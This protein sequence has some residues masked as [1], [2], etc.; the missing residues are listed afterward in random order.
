MQ[1]VTIAAALLCADALAAESYSVDPRH[2]YPVFEVSHLGFS[3]QRGRFNKTAGKIVLDRAA[4]SG[5]VDIV[6][7]VSSIDMGFEK[8]DAHLKS[9]DFL[10]AAK[11][12]EMRFS[13]KALRFTDGR[14]TGV[15]GELTL[16]GV[17]RPLAL[18]VTHFHCGVQVTTKRE[19]CGADALGTIRRSEFGITKFLP[20]VGDEIKLHIAV[21]AFRD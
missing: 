6:V 21:E 8:W 5:S 7:D 12:P 15:E 20:A 11:Y 9:E 10:D 17:T 2:T 1:A 3:T 18:Q 14:L 4:S 13:S 19:A 16:H